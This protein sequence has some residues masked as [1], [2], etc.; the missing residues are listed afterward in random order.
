MEDG[1]RTLTLTEKPESSKRPRTRHIL[2]LIVPQSVTSS[3]RDKKHALKRR[4][5]VEDS[6]HT[7]KARTVFEHV[8]LADAVETTLQLQTLPVAKGAYSARSL[9]G[10]RNDSVREYTLVDLEG[11]GITVFRWNGRYACKSL[12]GFTFLV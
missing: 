8:Q 4:K 9:V 11:L 3:H 12:P 2:P 5:A 10:C 6:R 7:A 1:L